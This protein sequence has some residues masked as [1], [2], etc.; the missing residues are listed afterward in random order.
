M[1]VIEIHEPMLK[2]TDALLL[3]KRATAV[4][5]GVTLQMASLPE[6]LALA[7]PGLVRPAPAPLAVAPVRQLTPPPPDLN[8]AQAQLQTLE[9]KEESLSTGLAFG[10]GNLQNP[11]QLP[12]EGLG[13]FAIRPERDAYHGT[14]DMIGGLIETCSALQQADPEMQPLGI[15]DISGPKGG[16]ISLHL[17]HRNG[18]DADLLFFATDPKGPPVLAEDFVRFNERGRGRYKGK[19]I[20]FDTRRNWALVRGLLTNRRFGS[21]VTALF[22]SR[23][24]RKLLL[25]HAAKTER[26]LKVLGRA[27]WLLHQ[28]SNHAGRHDD[29]FH[30]RIRCSAREAAMGCKG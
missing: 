3:A 18:R 25:D 20:V 6:T 28:P 26:D 29:H 21:R 4:A 12:F 17:S 7:N 15:G 1:F 14:D 8:T 11:A 10:R 23:P 24:L 19:T 9:A 22:V 2:L 30:I 27:R 13:Y 16:R 5:L